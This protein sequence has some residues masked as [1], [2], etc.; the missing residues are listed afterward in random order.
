V[1]IYR[2][3]RCLK[4]GRKKVMIQVKN[5]W[6][7]KLYTV[8]QITG[9][10]VVLRRSDGSE[11]TIEYKEYKQNYREVADNGRQERRDPDKG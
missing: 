11:F 8:M 5:K 10:A 4:N 2:L 3:K 9:A 1:R 6:N 7:N